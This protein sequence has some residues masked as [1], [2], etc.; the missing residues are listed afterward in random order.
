MCVHFGTST[1]RRILLCH[2]PTYSAVDSIWSMY[3]FRM[4]SC[5]EYIVQNY[6][7]LSVSAALPP[8]SPPG[9][10]PTNERDGGSTVSATKGQTVTDADTPPARLAITTDIMRRF[11]RL[12]EARGGDF[13]TVMLWGVACTCFFG[14]LRSGEATLPLALA[15]HLSISDVLVDSRSA[16]SKVLVRIKASKT[17][18][19]RLGVTMCMTFNTIR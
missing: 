1:V 15:A 16:P 18:P 14:F 13:N 2:K 9:L 10:R 19:F 8:E 17:D 5:T 7:V 12:W 11:R 3:I 6:K 4:A